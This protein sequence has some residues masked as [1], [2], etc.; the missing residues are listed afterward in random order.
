[1]IG[2]LF[3]VFLSFL[4]LALV[5]MISC[6]PCNRTGFYEVQVEN[7]TTDPL[8]RGRESRNTKRNVSRIID[9]IFAILIPVAFIAFVVVY[10]QKF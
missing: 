4:E 3:F 7:E 2:C 10:A 5:A 1:M 8:I 9:I 6:S